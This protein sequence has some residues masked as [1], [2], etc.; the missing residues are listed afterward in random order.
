MSSSDL[1]ELSSALSTEDDLSIDSVKGSSLDHYFGNGSTATQHA[2]PPAKKKRPA[3]PPHE[4]VLAD[5][6][7]IAVGFALISTHFSKSLVR[8]I[9]SRC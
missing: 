5:N 7:D 3:S 4:Y 1:S 6:P 9:L 8:S 2:P